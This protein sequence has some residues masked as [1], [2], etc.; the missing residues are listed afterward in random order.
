MFSVAVGDNNVLLIMPYLRHW[1]CLVKSLGGFW[2]PMPQV[3]E[4][5][6]DPLGDRRRVTPNLGLPK[7]QDGPPHLLEM[8]GILAVAFHVPLNLREPVVGVRT[9]PEL[10]ATALPVAAMP[11]VTVAEDC[12]FP[13]GKNDVGVPWKPGDVLQ[14]TVTSGP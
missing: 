8:E 14:E 5:R 13:L 12:D 7:P 10:L 1:V 9:G 2:P 11:E 4:G 6:S 3:V